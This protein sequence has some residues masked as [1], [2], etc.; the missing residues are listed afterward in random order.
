M[1][2]PQVLAAPEQWLPCVPEAMAPVQSEWAE[3]DLKALA[4]EGGE[5]GDARPSREYLAELHER[6]SRNPRGFQEVWVAF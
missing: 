3:K 4:S 6:R 1:C 5:E 2:H